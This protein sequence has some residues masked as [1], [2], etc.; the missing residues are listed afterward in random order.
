MGPCENSHHQD[1]NKLSTANQL[2]DDRL[3][4]KSS[5]MISLL[6]LILMISSSALRTDQGRAMIYHWSMMIHDVSLLNG[7][8]WSLIDEWWLVISH[9]VTNDDS[10]SFVGDWCQI[11][12]SRFQ[13]FKLISWRL[14]LPRFSKTLEASNLV[15]SF[16]IPFVKS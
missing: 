10:W 8:W 12:F 4:M 15:F 16:I 2:D 11:E 9:Y 5:V 14:Q 6:V 13:T 7:D 3:M 1:I